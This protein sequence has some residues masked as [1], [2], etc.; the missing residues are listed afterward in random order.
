MEKTL[1]DIFQHPWQHWIVDNFLSENCLREL[2]SIPFTNFQMIKGK[3]TGSERLFITEKNKDQHPELFKLHQSLEDGEYKKFF[4]TCTGLKFDELYVRVEVISDFGEFELEEHCDR[5]EKKLSAMV[6]TDY[7]E[8][9]PGT[10][11]TNGHQIESKDNRCFFFVPSSETYHSYPL[12]NFKK[13]RRC[14]MINYWTYTV[15]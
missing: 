5:P 1:P 14:L 8:L 9:Y 6:Y 7:E 12:T 2:K 11:L 10:L 15:R 13:V 3:R 4:E